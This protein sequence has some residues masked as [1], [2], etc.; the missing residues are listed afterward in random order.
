MDAGFEA[1]LHVDGTSFRADDA[2]LLRAIE[3]YR[4]LN[5]AAEALGRSYSRA[6]A[7]ITA[8]ERALGP[9][10]ERHRGGPDGG[11]S[12]LTTDARTLLARFDRLQTALDGTTRANETVVEGTVT[13]REGELATVDT[14]AGP[15]RVLLFDPAETVQ[16]SL[17][18]DAVTLH[19][20]DTAPP[21]GG[22]SARNRFRGTVTDVDRHEA[23]ARVAVDVG[24]PTPVTA[25]VTVGSLDRLGLEPGVP[26]VASAKATATHATP[27]RRSGD[28]DGT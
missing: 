16:V 13:D 21:A 23:I 15:I 27:V 1:H 25:V 28:P 3:E 5:A 12:E 2:A 10:V 6:H 9:L 26:V 24:L 14:P 11:G 18:E 19:E 22:T 17:R 8:L 4:S 20:P 7:R